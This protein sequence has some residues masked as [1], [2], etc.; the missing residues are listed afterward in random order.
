MASLKFKL[1]DKQRGIMLSLARFKVVAAGRRGGKSYLSAVL[2][3]IEALKM[4][5]EAGYNLKNKDVW[6]V[7]PTFQQAKDIMWA[8]LKD[9]G[10][11][12]I[13]STHENT[14][15][16]TLV[17]GRRICLKGSDR[18]DTLRGVGISYVVL[19]EYAS[20]KPEVWDL[21]IRATLADVEGGALFIGTPDGKNHFY[22]MWVDAASDE[23]LEWESFHFNSLDNPMI[24]PKEIEHAR[25]TMSRQAFAQEFEA[26]FASS[27]GGAFKEDEFIIAKDYPHQG[28]TFITVDP[29]GFTDTSQMLKSSEKR[30]DEFVI[31][32][33]RVTPNGWFVE[34]M[35]H[36]RWGIR[37][38]SIK[39]LRAYQTYH[40]SAVGIEK[41]ALKAAIMPYLTDQMGRLGV[42]FTPHDLLHGNKKKTERIIWSLQG[43]FQHGRITFKEA[44]WNRW[45]IGQLL[46][47]PNP[48]AHDDGPDALAYIDQ[49]SQVSYVAEGIFEQEEGFI[50]DDEAGY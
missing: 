43:R 5:N 47:F 29:A 21:I 13:V 7:A 30:L 24:S 38:A 10:E 49:I 28:H 22:D 1:H 9:L 37:E 3:L 12:V 11:E 40:P 34:D 45:L 6:Y 42:Y 14:A 33:T 23:W 31:C 26:S 39:L 27:G 32:V 2:L 8:L 46:D 35:Q 17:N 18:P 4:E 44:D 48:L 25:M 41:G 36:G 50:L 16:A 15:T 20:M 19:D